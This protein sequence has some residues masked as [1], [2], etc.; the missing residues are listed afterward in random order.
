MTS[1][2][3]HS[4]DPWLALPDLRPSRG[5]AYCPLPLTLACLV[6]IVLDLRGDPASVYFSDLSSSEACEKP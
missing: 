5:E 3:L 2:T 4:E 6:G 1:F